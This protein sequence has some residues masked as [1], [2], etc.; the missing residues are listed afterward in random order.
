MF[1][2]PYGR[3]PCGSGPC[4]P[5]PHT[6]LFSLFPATTIP[7][8]AF[9]LARARTGRPRDRPGHAHPFSIPMHRVLALRVDDAHVYVRARLTPPRYLY[10][11]LGYLQDDKHCSSSFLLSCSVTCDYPL[12]PL[13]D[14]HCR[15]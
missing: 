6:P 7:F 8:I 13:D 10:L 12:L 14:K 1:F 11:P 9:L 2:L 15:Y 4:R 5:T 3:R